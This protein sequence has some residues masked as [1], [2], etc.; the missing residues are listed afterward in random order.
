[1]GPERYSEGAERLIEDIERLNKNEF[2]VQDS[3]HCFVKRIKLSYVESAMS[4]GI[5][6]RRTMGLGKW[7]RSCSMIR[8]K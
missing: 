2:R 4:D 8:S 3:G 7:Y 5:N 6:E 1:M